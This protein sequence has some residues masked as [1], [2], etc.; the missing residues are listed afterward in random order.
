MPGTGQCGTG[1][2]QTLTIYTQGNRELV[3]TIWGERLIKQSGKG[4]SPTR[5]GTGFQNKKGSHKTINI[6]ELTDKNLT[7]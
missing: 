1:Q 7:Q 4:K 3:E 6:T 2:G 5:K